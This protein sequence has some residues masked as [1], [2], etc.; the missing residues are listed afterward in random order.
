MHGAA[1]AVTRRARIGK[2]RWFLLVAS[3]VVLVAFFLPL[4][5]LP[6]GQQNS[7]FDL[8]MGAFS[9]G[10]WTPARVLLA[11]LL[12]VSVGT[13]ATTAFGLLKSVASRP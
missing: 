8:T 11:V 4:L 10:R 12:V 1:E 6:F 9:G 2:G 5:E 7:L 13:L 3:V